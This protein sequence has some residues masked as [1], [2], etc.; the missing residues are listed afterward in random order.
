[1]LG[2]TA[3][4]GHCGHIP[5][6]RPVRGLAGAL[7]PVWKGLP[8][9]QPGAEW[10]RDKLNVNRCGRIRKRPPPGDPLPIIP[11]SRDSHL[12]LRAE[13]VNLAALASSSE[14]T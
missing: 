13:G 5:V 10:L 6:S 11:T 2:A 12:T 1:M 7:V 3:R 8:G 9:G 14:K 4:H